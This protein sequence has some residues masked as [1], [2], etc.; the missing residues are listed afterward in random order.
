MKQI[1]LIFGFVASLF[2]TCTTTTFNVDTGIAYSN[3]AYAQSVCNNRLGLYFYDLSSSVD[4]STSAPTD[5]TKTYY[6]SQSLVSALQSSSKITCSFNGPKITSQGACPTG[7]AYDPA[8]CS[9][10]TES[11]SWA[12]SPYLLTYLSESN[13][14][15]GIK[16]GQQMSTSYVWNFHWCSVDSKCYG[17]AY[18]CPAH[19]VYDVFLG[20][21]RP[22]DNSP[23]PK[24]PSG[25]YTE[26]KTVQ[27]TSGTICIDTKICKDNPSDKYDYEV[28]CASGQLDPG[29]PINPADAPDP[30]TVDP[31]TTANKKVCD[32]F[33]SNANLNCLLQHKKLSFECDNSTGIVT[34][35][36]CVSET[37]SEDTTINEG[38]N[39]KGS[40]T[41][42]I[43]TLSNELPAKI[44]SELSEFFTDGSVN[45]LDQIRNQLN[46]SLNVQA[47]QSDTLKD[48]SSSMDGMLVR[49][50]GTNTRLDTANAHLSG[51]EGA[52]NNQS[53]SISNLANVLQSNESFN[54]E[55][56]TNT[57]LE[58][59]ANTTDGFDVF[60]NGISEV[61]NQF[62]EAVNILSGNLPSPAFE[63]T[64]SCPSYS[65][66][67]NTVSL[68]KVGDYLRPYSSVIALIVYIG[69]MIPLFKMVFSFFG[70]V[71]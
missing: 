16:I 41:E 68:S 27:D 14:H 21:C 34:K 31:K 5:S 9:C 51:I 62:D 71:G 70:K 65:F 40:T 61:K 39:T 54:G 57:N 60:T 35:S 52:I 17:V 44:K 37:T 19:Q 43:K 22:L 36:E 18:S 6:Y 55:D 26:S 8:S 63:Q 56:V 10:K 33:R 32:S 29:T 15:N 20:S 46:E 25:Y 28:S 12:V 38:D 47:S 58:P 23:S 67:G 42:D 30:D 45:F 50:D 1:F 7:Q 4:P 48:I 24:C 66:H 11:C 2:A 3:S 69:M 53:S 59:D 13:C 64:G 49:Q